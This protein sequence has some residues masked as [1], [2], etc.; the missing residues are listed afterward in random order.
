M[1]RNVFKTVSNYWTPTREWEGETAFIVCGG[2]SAA[3][4]DL[5]RLR[6]HK[7]IATNTSIFAVPFADFTIFADTRWWDDNYQDPEFRKILDG[8]LRVVCIST[9]VRHKRILRMRRIEAG[10]LS[11][12]P[13]F[14]RVKYTVTVSA[15]NLCAH[16]G[17][18]KIVTVGLDGKNAADGKTHHHAT[19]RPHPWKQKPGAFDKQ[20]KDFTKAAD[21]LKNLGIACVNASPGSALAD[22]FPVVDF[23]AAVDEDDARIAAKTAPAQTVEQ[24]REGEFADS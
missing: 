4:Q 2:P 19:T 13:N 12:D 14:L 17:V 1:P 10:G 11:R 16:L 23:D 15:M 6:G 5:S 21:D 8:P 3:L 7:V 24:M 20:R 18:S 9:L 22:I